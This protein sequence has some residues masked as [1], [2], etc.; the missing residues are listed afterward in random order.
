MTESILINR[1]GLISAEFVILRLYEFYECI[2]TAIYYKSILRIYY[3]HCSKV[4]FKK[5]PLTG[6]GPLCK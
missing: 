3:I 4:S 5:I 1:A 6:K 2:I